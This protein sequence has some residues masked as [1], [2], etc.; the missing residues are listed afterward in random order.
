MQKP[1]KFDLD[2]NENIAFE[3]LRFSSFAS[4]CFEVTNLEL[5]W[6]MASLQRF[7]R[8]FTHKNLLQFTS[9]VLIK[10]SRCCAVVAGSTQHTL[11][12][13]KRIEKTREAALQGGGK[14]RIAKQHEKVIAMS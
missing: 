4:V 5:W 13:R 9:N 8:C 10:Q 14:K 6:K 11:S 2:L 7:A 1:G 12:V 3:I